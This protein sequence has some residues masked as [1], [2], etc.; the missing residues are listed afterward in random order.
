[1][2]GQLLPFP[3]GS[4]RALWLSD[5][6]LGSH[7][8]K[9]DYLADLLRRVHA[10][11]L[12][13]VGDI[14]DLWCV[15]R[16]WRWG[17][18]QACAVRAIAAA[19]RRGT[20]VTYLPGNHDRLVADFAGPV[21]AGLRIQPEAVHETAEGRRLLVFHG[22][23]LEAA[24]KRRPRLEAVGDGAYGA[25]QVLDRYLLAARRRAGRPYWSLA[26]YL[27]Q[28]VGPAVSYVRRFEEAGLREAARRGADGV[29][30]GHVHHPAL[31]QDRER[32]YANTGDWVESCSALVEHRDGRLELL[33]W[34]LGEA[35]SARPPRPGGPG[36]VAGVAVSR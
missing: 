26:A 32:W 34:A 10:D 24:V 36:E 25:V 20:R 17:E 30:C 35:A 29:V 22:D 23:H 28:R 5:T 27:K 9:A 21:L 14:F 12:Y 8:C 6:H 11:Q 31:R 33:R 7:A 1:M 13:L 3:P 16:R 4:Y 15:G 2:T 18:A 19:A